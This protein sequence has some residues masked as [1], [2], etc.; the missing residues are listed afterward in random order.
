MK[1]Q[2]KN[3]S[4]KA[5]QSKILVGLMIFIVAVLPVVSAFDFDNVK[6]KIDVNKNDKLIIGDKQLNYNVLWEKYK[7][8]QIDNAFGLGSTLFK[9]A[10]VEHTDT[11]V[12]NCYST[13]EIYLGSESVLVDEIKFI[14][15]KN[16]E[17][18]N[19]NYKLFYSSSTEKVNIDDYA[20]VCKNKNT[21]LNGTIISECNY[22]KVGSHQ[23]DK[24]V[25]KEFKVGDS[26]KSGTYKIKIEGIKN[27]S[28]EIDWIVTSQGK[29]LSEWATWGSSTLTDGLVSYYKFDGN[30]QDSIGTGQNLTDVGTANASGIIGSSR[31]FTGNKYANRI[32]GTIP[33]GA[34]PVT[35]CLWA[36]PHGTANGQLFFWGGNGTATRFNLQTD[37]SHWVLGG[38]SADITGSSSFT[39]NSRWYFICGKQNDTGRELFVDGKSEGNL[40]RAFDI[41]GTTTVW[42]GFNDQAVQYWNGLIDEIGVW[43]RSLTNTEITQLNNSGAGMTY[44]FVSA[45]TL[46]SPA[47]ASTQTASVTLTSSASVYGATLINVTLWDNRTGTWAARN[48]TTKTGTTNTSSFTNTYSTGSYKWNMKWCDSDGACGFATSNYTFKVDATAP[49]IVV[50]GGNSTED[51]GSLTTNHTIN[52]TITDSGLSSCWLNYNST[53]RTIPCLSGV[54]NTTNFTMQYN[55]YNATIFANDTAGNVGSKFFNWSYYIFEVSKN[56]PTSTISGGKDNVNITVDIDST[57]YP[58]SYAYLSRNGTLFLTTKT[59]SG[60]STIFNYEL[61]AP[62]VNVATNYSLSFIF[63]VVYSN[64]TSVNITG[65]SYTQTVT[66]IS[67]DDCSTNSIKILNYTLFDE[68]NSTLVNGTIDL[69]LQIKSDS[70]VSIGNYTKSFTNVNTASVCLNSSL[71]ST[72]LKMDAEASYYAEDYSTR[73]NYIQGHNLTTATSPQNVS[74]YLLLSSYSTSFFLQYKDSSFLYKEGVLIN[75]QKKFVDENVYRTVEIEKTDSFGGATGYFNLLEN[76]IYTITI[77][78]NGVLTYSFGNVALYCVSGTQCQLNLYESATE[79]TPTDYENYQN[80]NYNNDVNV[81]GR[82][83]TTTFSTTDSSV[84]SVRLNVIKSDAYGNNTICNNTVTSSAGQISCTIPNSYG[85]GTIETNLFKDGILVV[86][87]MYSLTNYSTKSF[88]GSIVLIS[89][90]ILLTLPLLFSTSPIYMVLAGTGGFFICTILFFT[91]GVVVLGSSVLI[92]IFTIVF[93]FFWKVNIRSEG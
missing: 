83:I 85:N 25:W 43:N 71:G 13:L 47:D 44:P 42:V 92:W 61:T 32:R 4:Y 59:T 68:R 33:S 73:H 15:V 90:L 2:Q 8:I 78:E 77:T 37:A 17:E 88:A 10:I 6:N 34:D 16:N 45:V 57:T 69:N 21:L 19:I 50:N 67:I 81:S 79:I 56:T 40:S 27:P 20:D 7:P 23:E 29:S 26:F 60:T 3:T 86:K 66:P 87:N 84:A 62:A 11:C 48:I 18:K 54:L 64:G 41:N 49:T 91:S 22:E 31:N 89:L 82:I 12:D 9:G 75:I 52:Y 63:V 35:V 46:T 30:L 28:D 65:N 55:V 24:D 51:Y 70:D 1:K 38:Y 74:L 72:T 80:L 39:A 58:S 14:N 76:T 93:I 53:N 36:Y 5:L